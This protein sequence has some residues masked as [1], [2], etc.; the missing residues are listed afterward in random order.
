[1]AFVTDGAIG[2]DLSATSTTIQ[3]KLGQR[4]TADNGQIY[5]YVLAGAAINAYDCVAISNAFSASGMTKALADLGYQPGNAP[6]AIADAS[7]GWVCIHGEGLTQTV[8]ASCDKGLSLFTT[9]VTGVLDDATG[10]QTKIWGAVLITS[11][12]TAATTSVTANFI[13]PHTQ[14]APTN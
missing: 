12:G 11:A 14:L 6:V 10:S 1:M 2:V 5:V 9:A 3:W 4:V 13:N 7:Y 8:L